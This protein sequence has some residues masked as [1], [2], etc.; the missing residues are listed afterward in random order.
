MSKLRDYRKLLAELA[1]LKDSPNLSF[2]ERDAALD[3]WRVIK[4][5]QAEVELEKLTEAA[6]RAKGLTE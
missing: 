5:L 3:A 6:A 1:A 2:R 4:R